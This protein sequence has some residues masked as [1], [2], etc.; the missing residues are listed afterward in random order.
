[1]TKWEPYHVTID[2]FEIVETFVNAMAL[3]MNEILAKHGF[4]VQV[5]TYVKDEW[6]N[7]STKTTVLTSIVSCEVLG[8]TTPF[9]GACHV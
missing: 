4:N 2:F 6:G 1:M 8:L 5:I 9:V 7:L 3:Q